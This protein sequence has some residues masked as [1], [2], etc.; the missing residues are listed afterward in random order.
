MWS[1]PEIPGIVWVAGDTGEADDNAKVMSLGTQSP[2]SSSSRWMPRKSR[3]MVKREPMKSGLAWPPGKSLFIGPAV[4]NSSNVDDRL[5]ELLMRH[6]VLCCL[7]LF[8]EQNMVFWVR[9]D[10]AWGWWR[11]R[12]CS[13]A[14]CPRLQGLLVLKKIKSGY[15]RNWSRW[16]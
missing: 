4:T 5:G 16:K 3:A 9:W 1:N 2:L 14:D 11:Q 12:W 8:S 13:Q 6:L 10:L 15:V 7:L